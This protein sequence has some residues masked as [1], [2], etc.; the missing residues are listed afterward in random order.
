MSSTHS[1]YIVD[2]PKS[3]NLYICLGM[4]IPDKLVSEFVNLEENDLSAFE[5]FYF[6]HKEHI[7]MHCYIADRIYANFILSLQDIFNI[8][9]AKGMMLI[10]EVLNNLYLVHSRN[11]NYNVIRTKNADSLI[12]YLEEIKQEL[13][14]RDEESAF[15]FIM[16]CN[17]L[18]ENLLHDRPIQTISFDEIDELVISFGIRGMCDDLNKWLCSFENVRCVKK[19]H[20]EN[21]EL[22]QILQ[23]SQFI[24]DSSNLEI[25]VLESINLSISTF[26]QRVIY[27]YDSVS[28]ENKR[29]LYDLWILLISIRYNGV[30]PPPFFE[31]IK[32]LLP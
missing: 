32:R 17:D 29:E 19:M 28:E 13:I 27:D 30:V 6:A 9:D 31:A 5:R 22:N 7:N 14:I 18:M 16:Q 21:E 4:V 15:P 11:D 26:I 2:S 23:S 12:G 20:Y 1:V 25:Q 10:R 3:E 8:K 24:H